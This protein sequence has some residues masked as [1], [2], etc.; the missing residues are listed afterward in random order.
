MKG[1]KVKES[2]DPNQLEEVPAATFARGSRERLAQAFYEFD[3]QH[4][5]VPQRPEELQKCREE[6]TAAV[7]DY[8]HTESFDKE[9]DPVM[10]EILEASKSRSEFATRL[11][12]GPTVRIKLYQRPE[13]EG[14]PLPDEFVSVHGIG[15]NIPR[16]KAVTVPELFEQIL[17]Q[18]GRA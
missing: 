4:L 15:A 2:T 12:I 1:A 9:K 18:A 3:R 14:N 10:F 16:G 6:V 5:R 13:R 17:E 7:F 8:E 11:L